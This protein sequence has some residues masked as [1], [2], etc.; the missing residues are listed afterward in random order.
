MKDERQRE[1]KKAIFLKTEICT[2][3]CIPSCVSY[4]FYYCYPPHSLL[5]KGKIENNQK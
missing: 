1:G 2:K 3:V 4:L 5:L